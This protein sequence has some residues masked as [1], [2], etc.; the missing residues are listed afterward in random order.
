MRL[1]EYE[2]K[3][4]EKV[5]NFMRGVEAM[6]SGNKPCTGVAGQVVTEFA[7]V[8]KKSHMTSPVETRLDDA[9]AEALVDEILDAFNERNYSK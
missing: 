6:I 5:K 8:L 4:T 2:R 7:P 3:E 1:D 9:T